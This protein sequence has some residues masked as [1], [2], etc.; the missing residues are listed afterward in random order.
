MKVKSYRDHSALAML[1]ET[2]CCTP[3][4]CE[5]VA[6]SADRPT[7]GSALARAFAPIARIGRSFEAR[8][9]KRHETRA[10]S[11]LTERELEDIGISRGELGNKGFNDT[12]S[13]IWV[14]PDLLFFLR[15]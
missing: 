14:V 3:C 9:L 15:K 10:L 5:Q 8:R 6:Y 1:D 4:A 2:N 11:Q 7:A 13:P 12:S